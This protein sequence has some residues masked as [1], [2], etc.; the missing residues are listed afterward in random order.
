MSGA[1][2]GPE[3]FSA[4]E[5]A[6][7]GA[8]PQQRKRQRPDAGSPRAVPAAV[9]QAMSA[10]RGPVACPFAQARTKSRVAAGEQARTQSSP[11]R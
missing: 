5:Y 8:R 10:D 6:L 3:Y 1:D 2:T 7:L 4:L 11:V 9:P